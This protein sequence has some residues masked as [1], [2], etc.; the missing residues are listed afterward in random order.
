MDKRRSWLKRILLPAITITI[1]IAITIGLQLVYGRHPERLLELQNYVYLGA[2]L[3]SLIGNATVILPGAVLVILT[4]I[5]IVL[6]PVTG[7]FGPVLVGVAGGAGAAIGEM[8]GYM[9]GYSGRGVVEKSRL[10]LRLV[11]W[12]ERWGIL[13]VFIFSVVPFFFDLVGIIAGALRFPVW[14]FA[15]FCWLG[16]S[17]MYVGVIVASALGYQNILPYFS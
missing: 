11:G 2:F 13:T 15:L 1:V 14:K 5:G 12:M 10:Y 6:C 16:R 9:V 8:T 7:A 17:L 3:I 4:N